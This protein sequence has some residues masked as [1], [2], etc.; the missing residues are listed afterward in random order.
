MNQ[1]HANASTELAKDYIAKRK[2]P[3][4][5]EALIT[6]LM[7]H[8]PENHIEFIIESL[9]RFKDG[10]QQI[11]W[12]VFIGRKGGMKNTLAPLKHVTTT[13]NDTSVPSSSTHPELS[14]S[15]KLDAI[16][17]GKREEV[18][19]IIEDRPQSPAAGQHREQQV[20][21]PHQQSPPPPHD[22]NHKQEDQPQ[23]STSTE[24][25]YEKVDDHPQSPVH[26][27]NHKQE[28]DDR[29]QP[30]TPTQQQQKVKD[31]PQSPTPT[32]QQQKVE[33]RPQS[34]TP[35][36]QQQKVEDRPPSPTLDQEQQHKVED[37]Q[38]TQEKE[39]KN[40]DLLKGKPI[41]FIGGGPGSGKGTQCEKMIEQ[42]G[43]THLSA[44]DLIRA[45]AQDP[46]TEK[47]RYFNEAMS[48][49][50]LVSTDDILDLLKDAIYEKA[51]EASGFLIDGFPRRVDQGIKFEQD[52]ALCD[53]LIYFDVPDEVMTERLINR[54]KTSGRIDDNQE[55]IAKRLVTFHEETTPI[56]GYYGKQGKLVTIEANREPDEVFADVK[57]ALEGLIEQNQVGKQ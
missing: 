28:T 22:Q 42:Y 48:Q 23:S 29:S 14:R 57:Q 40:K 46:S 49:G 30:S 11:K 27:Q 1:M 47:G 51:H 15:P 20:E 33:D 16:P 36:Q 24:Q 17:Q 9:S 6:G 21:D 37:Q 50:K 41:L 5:F 32:Q 8:K 45:A 10:D 38:H 4:L 2:I 54:G 7:V 19:T 18:P 43:F 3:Q 35:T 44:G 12:D 25:Q 13:T 26:D 31:R 34:P 53:A 56:L 39:T 52:V 55:T